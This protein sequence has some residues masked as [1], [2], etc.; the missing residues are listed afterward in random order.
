MAK[1]RSQDELELLLEEAW[2]GLG[3]TTHI[4]TPNDLKDLWTDDGESPLKKFVRY[5]SNPDNFA[6]TCQYILGV[7]LMPFQLVILQELWNHRF[8]ILIMTRGGSKSWSLAVYTLLRSLLKPE[9]KTVVVG[10][11][12]RQSKVIFE[13]CDVIWGKAPV[14]RSICERGY[15]SKQG[16]RRDTDRA[17]IQICDSQA[18]FLPIGTGEKIRGQRANTIISDEF[19]ALDS[20]IYEVVISGFGAVSASPVENVKKKQQAE[21]ARSLGLDIDD[22]ALDYNQSI[23]SGTCDYDFNHFARYWKRY[24]AII[25]SCG[26]EKQLAEIFKDTKQD[27][28]NYSVMRIPHNLLPDGYLDQATVARAAATMHSVHFLLEYNTVFAKDSMGFFKRTLLDACVVSPGMKKDEFPPGTEVFHPMLV[29]NSKKKYVFAIDPASEIDNFSVV[30]LELNATHRRIVY[31]WTTSKVEYKKELNSGKTVESDFYGYCVRKIRQLMKV[32][33]C[34]IIGCDAQGGGV[35]IREALHNTHYINDGELPIWEVIDREKPKDTDNKFGQHILELIQFADGDWT[36]E[37]N[38]G[39]RKDFEDKVLLFPYY[40]SASLEL[41]AID[42]E[43]MERLGKLGHDSM[44][45]CTFEIEELKNELTTIIQ[46]QTNSG[47]DRWDTPETK[48]TVTNKK[49][50]LRKDR[51]SALVIAN[52][53]GRQLMMADAPVNFDVHGGY[54]QK[55]AQR[56][57]KSQRTGKL[58]EGP[59]W[60]NRQMEAAVTAMRRRR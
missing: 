33:P 4:K 59:D 11:G 8:P 46:T 7:Q 49:G 1:M 2:Y 35:A 20:N 5:I 27:W 52:M 21:F 41:A 22:E 13:Y 44:E 60:Y 51:Y 48:S 39:M 54:A 55:I 38:H 57:N 29:G 15:Y 40:D 6:F 31:V 30:V 17:V 53:I 50:R 56:P 32:F 19:A 10:A 37:A 9:H 34:E 42:D 26:D 58:F 28:E 24:K 43:E 18:L 12:F 47:R 16:P 36:A 23:I 14:L 25:G 45:N 3:D